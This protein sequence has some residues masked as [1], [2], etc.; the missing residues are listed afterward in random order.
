[1]FIPPAQGFGRVASS[2]GLNTLGG[3]PGR[4]FER[5]LGLGSTSLRGKAAINAA[6]ARGRAI[7]YAGRQDRNAAIFGGAMSALGSLGSA[8]IRSGMF[9]GGGG[10]GVGDYSSVDAQVMGTPTLEADYMGTGKG[11]YWDTDM[12]ENQYTPIGYRTF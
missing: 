2:L 7:E 9:G 5:E 1:M 8:G 10:G 4:D 3:V 12:G 11:L 6:K